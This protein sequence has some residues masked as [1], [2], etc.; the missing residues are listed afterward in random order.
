MQSAYI[1]YNGKT[2]N[3][4]DPFINANNR[5][6]RYG[7]GLFETMRLEDGEVAL[8][9]YHFE[10]LFKGLAILKFQLPSS[11]TPQFLYESIQQL[12]MKNKHSN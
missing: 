6:F 1:N 9:K 7:D 2:I 4:E 12:C 11:F 10:R 5:G 8:Q 3:S